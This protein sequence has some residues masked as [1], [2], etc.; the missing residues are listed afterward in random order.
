MK[1]QQLC[2]R[3]GAMSNI[4]RGER[5]RGADYCCDNV[6]AWAQTAMERHRGTNDSIVPEYNLM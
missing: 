4:K 6:G 1:G 5:M 2:S 3:K